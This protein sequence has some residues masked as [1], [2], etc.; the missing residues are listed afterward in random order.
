M[1]LSRV[2][3]LLRPPLAAPLRLGGQVL[4]S[5]AAVAGLTALLLITHPALQQATASL[6]YV[7]VVVLVAAAFGLVPAIAGAIGAS[8]AFNYYFIAPRHA[9]GFTSVED[10]L[11]L[12][13]FVSVAV[14][15]GSVAGHARSQA[16]AAAERLLAAERARLADAAARAEAL[17]ESDRLK[18]TLLSSVSHDL[19]TPLAVIKGAATNL[20]DESVRWDAEARRELLGAIDEETDRLHRL[21]GDLLA[22]SRIEAGAL[23]TAR[24]WEDIG[25]LAVAVVARLRP[26]CP[27]HQIVVD[28]PPALPPVRA[29][30]IQ[31]DQVLTN[32]IENAAHH[33][34]PGTTIEVRVAAPPAT[35]AP[36]R[37]LRVE[38]LDR[39]PGVPAGL[40]ERIFEK[41][42]RAEAPERSAHG[43]GLGL[44]ICRG[45]V[46]AHAGRIWA[47]GR[48]EGGSR[49][50]FTLPV[51]SGEE[52]G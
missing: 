30:Y 27:Q 9:L 23:P 42:V 6:L 48:P 14:I 25:E 2:H 22:M 49:F 20:L 40:R 11:R 33:A 31:I 17:A 24:S 1:R 19:R 43:S 45:L 15:A 29:S 44:A 37:A 18:S 7:L 28:L 50:I 47:E 12:F 16:L 39:G 8:V 10:G 51:Q 26:R 32:L 35:A 52:R 41:F 5:L 34:P 13:T 21:V 36:P 46:E 3:H 4:L 38:V